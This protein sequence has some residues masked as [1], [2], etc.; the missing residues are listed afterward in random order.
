MVT[1]E[2]VIAE[3]KK[4]D[5]VCPQPDKWNR[6]YEMLPNKKR[7]GNGWEPSLPL[8][9][10]AWRDTPAISKMLRLREHVEWAE[11]EQCLEEVYNFLISLNETDWHHIGD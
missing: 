2:E 4:N 9:L 6:L 10:A 7:K 8:I 11:K 5:R 1:L 3:V